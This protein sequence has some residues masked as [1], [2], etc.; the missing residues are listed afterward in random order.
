MDAPLDPVQDRIMISRSVNRRSKSIPNGGD[1]MKRSRTT[2]HSRNLMSA[3]LLSAAILTVLA[4]PA[5]GQQEMDPTLYDPS[6]AQVTMA[7]QSQAATA[8]QFAQD[9]SAQRLIATRTS[10]QADAS[11]SSTAGSAKS[12]TKHTQPGLHR[13][14]DASKNVAT[15]AAENRLPVATRGNEKSAPASVSSM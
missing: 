3:A 12:T 5:F 15:P 9:E 14:N 13:R 4:L 11:S 1:S 8:D 7:H 6:P 10:Q 2:N